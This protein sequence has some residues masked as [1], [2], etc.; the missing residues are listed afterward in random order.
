MGPSA[1]RNS[2]AEPIRAIRIEGSGRCSGGD[3]DAPFV[4]QPAACKQ[5]SEQEKD[6]R[7]PNNQLGCGGAQ[8]HGEQRR[9]GSDPQGSGEAQR[10]GRGENGRRR[11]VDS[12]GSILDVHRHDSKNK[13]GYEGR[14]P[15]QRAGVKTRTD[16]MSVRP[17][18]PEQIR[19]SRRRKEQRDEAVEQDQNGVEE[20][21]PAAPRY[22]DA[23]CQ[24]NEHIDG[25]GVEPQPGQPCVGQKTAQLPPQASGAANGCADCSAHDNSHLPRGYGMRPRAPCERRLRGLPERTKAILIPPGM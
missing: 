8:D 25:G 23:E 24:E 11:H 5:K 20:I 17:F 22:R 4:G 12:E 18:G 16:R 13:H 21:V 19:D 15:V 2:T 6:E 3:R 14:P 9:A 1:A 10:Q 7:C